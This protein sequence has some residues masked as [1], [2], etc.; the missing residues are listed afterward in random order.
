MYFFQWLKG[1]ISEGKF[2]CLGLLVEKS[3][4]FSVDK[5]V[6]LCAKMYMFWSIGGEKYI[7]SVDKSVYFCTK[8]CMFDPIGEEKCIFPVDKSVYFLSKMCMFGPIS[9]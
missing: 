7:F 3:I 4:F 1:Y 2:V 8:M 5:S 9:G 6:C